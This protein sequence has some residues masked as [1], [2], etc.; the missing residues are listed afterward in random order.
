MP[1]KCKTIQPLVLW[2]TKVFVTCVWLQP[3]PKICQK[4]N[5]RT[6][7]NFWYVEKIPVSYNFHLWEN[8]Y[9]RVFI[10]FSVR[11]ELYE[12][13]WKEFSHLWELYDKHFWSTR[14]STVFRGNEIFFSSII[15]DLFSL[16]WTLTMKLN[17]NRFFPTLLRCEFQ[18]T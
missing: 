10:H 9:H 17:Y 5:L 6:K 8:A 4:L 15:I 12:I 14:D 1:C 13:V 18:R 3:Q 7:N 2:V 16:L 11:M